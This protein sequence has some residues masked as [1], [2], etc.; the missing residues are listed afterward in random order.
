MKILLII[1]ATL[2]SLEGFSQSHYTIC[3]FDTANNGVI[4]L[5]KREYMTD[6]KN[7]I[8]VVNE[9]ESKFAK[10]KNVSLSFFD[11]RED[12]TAL[13]NTNENKKKDYWFA[14]FSTQTRMFEYYKRDGSF[15]VLWS[16]VINED[17][18][19]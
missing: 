9:I 12:C 3:K 5:A 8:R 1:I 7:T 6:L 11:E 13:T 14:E 15:S 19:L 18:K 16:M 4:I 10:Y 17:T 2:F